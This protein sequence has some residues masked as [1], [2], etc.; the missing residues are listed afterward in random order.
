MTK[1]NE[2]KD[3]LHTKLIE[4]ENYL[5][6]SSVYGNLAT[7]M[8]LMITI[9]ATSLSIKGGI[10]VSITIAVTGVVVMTVLLYEYLI[11]IK[12]IQRLKKEISQLPNSIEIVGIQF[13]GKKSKRGSS[14]AN[15][16]MKSDQ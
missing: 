13:S 1:T 7:V 10:V 11:R 12:N 2:N 16:G 5:K 6:K 14:T 3:Q 15:K 4:Q 9:L 8:S